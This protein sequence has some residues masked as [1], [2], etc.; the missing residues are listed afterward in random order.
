MT[1]PASCESLYQA[2]LKSSNYTNNQSQNYEH[3]QKAIS[4][5]VQN[6]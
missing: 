2:P 5:Q 3:L 4:D 1:Q 6:G